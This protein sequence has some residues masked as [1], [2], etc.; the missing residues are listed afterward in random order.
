M[1]ISK[2]LQHSKSSEACFQL[3]TSNKDKCSNLSMIKLKS[4]ANKVGRVK[5]RI[6]LDWIGLEWTGD[7]RLTTHVRR[8]KIKWVYTGMKSDSKLQQ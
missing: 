1:Y 5:V 2:L 6:G 4:K 3:S 7:S 8:K